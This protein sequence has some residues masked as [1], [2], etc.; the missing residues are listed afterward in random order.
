MVQLTRLNGAYIVVNANHIATIESTPDTM[1]TLLSG[2][3]LSVKETPDEVIERVILY[4]RRVGGRPFV[5][6]KPDNELTLENRS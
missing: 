6:P 1:L 2:E 5:V 3:K 4:Q